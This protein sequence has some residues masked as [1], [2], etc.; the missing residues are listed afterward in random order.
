VNCHDLEE[1]PHGSMEKNLIPVCFHGGDEARE[2]KKL[3]LYRSWKKLLEWLWAALD[4]VSISGFKSAGL[5]LKPKRG[6]W[7]RIKAMVKNI[8]AVPGSSS[9]DA[10]LR[11]LCWFR[12]WLHYFPA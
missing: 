5:S 3:G 2:K 9:I 6:N 4:Q 12:T 11:F 8:S 10:A 7:A 1:Q